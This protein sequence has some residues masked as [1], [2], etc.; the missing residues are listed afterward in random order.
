MTEH[1]VLADCR[2]KVGV[3]SSQ[4]AYYP[5]SS[6]GSPNDVANVVTNTG[7]TA[8]WICSTT[9][10]LFTTTNT[11]FTANLGPQVA[12]GQYA[13]TGDNGYDN[14]GFR[15]WQS[16]QEDYYT[17]GNTTCNMVYNCDHSAAPA[18]SSPTSSDASTPGLATGAVIGISV[19]AGFGSLI[20]IGAM[21]L[22]VRRLRRQ[23]PVELPANP[24][25]NPGGLL[26][27][28]KKSHLPTHS[29][30][31]PGETK[32]WRGPSQPLYEMDAQG[33]VEVSA[34]TRP[35]ELGGNPRAEMPT[36]ESQYYMWY[37]T[38]GDQYSS[39]LDGPPKMPK[40]LNLPFEL[41]RMIMAE[42]ILLRADAPKNDTEIDPLQEDTQVSVNDFQFTVGGRGH[43]TWIGRPRYNL[44]INQ[45]ML[46][47]RQLYAEVTAL[48]K[49]W[50]KK[51][52]QWILG[53]TC[54][55][56]GAPAALGVT[57]SRSRGL[58]IKNLIIDF[59]PTTGEDM[60]P[61][62]YAQSFKDADTVHRFRNGLGPDWIPQPSDEELIDSQILCV[63]I[64]QSLRRMIA[65]RIDQPACWQ[66]IKLFARVGNI[67]IRLAGQIQHHFN[68][69]SAL[70]TAGHGLGHCTKQLLQQRIVNKLDEEGPMLPFAAGNGKANGEE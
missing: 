9:V 23:R 12:D 27:M 7:E 22:M 61:L 70:S 49:H 62:D 25:R 37:P 42:V 46:V 15:C 26:G 50:A 41:R 43:V 59:L 63:H 52:T 65:T 38:D 56:L 45:L 17:Y 32:H 64:T 66:S 69:Q 67:E 6:G 3:Y 19:G 36:P 47:N 34:L 29:Q 1:V 21:F 24:A 10:G 53:M 16:F 30:T 39:P 35:G 4:M 40:L 48:I 28:F 44:T 5:T 2:D 58:K 20:A 68:M 55:E 13:G 60:L 14:G 33:R 31:H 18:S 51:P 8:L 54:T 57:Q 11:K